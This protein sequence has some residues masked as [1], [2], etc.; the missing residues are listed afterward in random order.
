MLNVEH[1]KYKN[2]AFD[3]KTMKDVN[4]KHN[5]TSY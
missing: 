4:D 3:M 2:S 1:Q 5:W